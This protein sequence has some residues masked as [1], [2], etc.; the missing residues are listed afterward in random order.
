MA[1]YRFQVM[2]QSS[3]GLCGVL[4][5]ETTEQFGVVRRLQWS[6]HGSGA[7]SG[8]S[9]SGYGSPSGSML[10]MQSQSGEEWARILH[11]A[12]HE[13][14]KGLSYT[15]QSRAGQDV[16]TLIENSSQHNYRFAA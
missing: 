4:R 16:A 14:R 6:Y 7:G 2:N 15:L 8:L 11:C 9:G 12:P 13:L 1:D 10:V 3:N 5:V